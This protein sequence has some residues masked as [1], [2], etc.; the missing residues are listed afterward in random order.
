MTDISAIQREIRSAGLTW[1]AGQTALTGLSADDQNRRLGLDVRPGELERISAQI[2][3]R[4]YEPGIAFASERDW[5]N[6]KGRN[7][8]TPIRDQGGCGSCVA[9]ATV[10]TIECQARI[11][12]KAPTWDVNLAEAD[13]FFCGAGKR[14]S[15]GWW[16]PEALDYART[17]GIPDDAC[18]PYQDHDMNCKGCADRPDK[19][20]KVTESK[21]LI[22]VAERKGW[23]DTNGPAIACLAI[24]RDFFAYKQGIYRHVTGDLAGYHAVSCVGYSEDEQAWICK[25]SWGNDWGDKGFFKIAYGEAEIDTKFP[26]WGVSG[27]T[28]TLRP[29]DTDDTDDEKVAMAEHV[30]LRY[31]DD[32]LPVL[33]ARA[34]GQW[35]SLQ[36]K[37]E[38]LDAVTTA[39]FGSTAVEVRYKGDGIVAL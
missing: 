9:F 17:K 29:A 15:Q 20:L 26:M 5:R 18:F 34:D 32:G 19:L 16:P 8:V 22:G 11:E 2:A 27:V 35:R 14:C 38:A 30:V 1:E 28:G 37:A 7:W 39:A 13:L 33:L 4:A 12:H 31:E 6:A 25:N 24:Y 21:E 23:I 3:A 36:L 10:A